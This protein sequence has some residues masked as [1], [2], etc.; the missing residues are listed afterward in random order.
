[1]LKIKFIS[2]RSWKMLNELNLCVKTNIFSKIS[3][4]KIVWQAFFWSTEWH[5]EVPPFAEE[6]NVSVKNARKI[7]FLR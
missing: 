1:M 2:S 6:A 7:A 3:T 4:R 5:K